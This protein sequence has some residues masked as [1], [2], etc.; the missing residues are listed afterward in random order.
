[1]KFTYNDY[2]H[3]VNNGYNNREGERIL[4]SVSWYSFPQVCGG[5]IKKLTMKS[6]KHNTLQY[7]KQ[8]RCEYGHSDR[9]VV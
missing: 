5:N 9:G 4:I 2:M 6:E 1:M 7:Y 3:P 8:K